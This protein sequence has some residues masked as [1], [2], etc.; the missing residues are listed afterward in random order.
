MK[1]I[2]STSAAGFYILLFAVSIGV[3]TFIENDFG[4][5]SA[6]KLV[7]KAWWFELLLTLFSITLVVNVVKFKMLQLK[8][9]PLFI[10][11]LSMVLILVGAGI[12]RYFSFE[13]TMHIREGDSSNTVLSR[14]NYLNFQAVS[15]GD[16]YEFSEP[17]LFSSIGNNSFNEKFNI[18]GKLVNV[19]VLDIMPNP[20]NLLVESENG[21]PI[22]KIV[23]GGSNG[24][25][26]FYI[27]D[28]ERRTISGLNFDFSK[29]LSDSSVVDFSESP[30]DISIFYEEGELFIKSKTELSEM[31]MIT[32]AQSILEKGIVHPLKLRSFYNTGEKGFV[33][34]AFVS[35]GEL[36][37][38]STDVKMDNS[39][40]VGVHLKVN[41]D[42]KE[43]D[44]Y[45]FGRTGGEGR[46]EVF[47][48]DNFE[49]SIS[50]G[51]KRINLPFGLYLNDF[52][53]DRY[54]GTNSPASYASEVTL[55]DDRTDIREDHRIYMNHILDHDGY[56]FFQSS[57]DQDELGTYL[58]VNHDYWGTL[59]TYISYALF[60]LGLV[61]VFFN[62][63]TRFSQLS[64]QLKTLQDKRFVLV[65]MLSVSSVMA[66]ASPIT[67]NLTYVSDSHA[68]LFNTTIV[69]D[70]KGRMKPMQ[71]LSNELLRK[72]H[73]KS[74]YQGH[75]AST[76]ILSMY[77]DPKVW[78]GAPMI[79][80]GKHE[81]IAE[82][83]GISP[84]EL[85]S[86][87]DFFFDD[88]SYKLGN[89]IKEANAKPP[90]ER[91]TYEKQLL[92]VDERV[93]IVGMV[94]AGS[95]FK[96]IPIENDVNNTWVAETSHL[97]ASEKLTSPVAEA[98][99]STYRRAVY[100]A[101]N[102]ASYELCDK[103]INELKNYQTTIGAAVIPSDLK[104]STE[105]A[106]NNS[107]VFNRLALFYF[108]LGMLFLGLLFY[109]V[110]F[111]NG[112]AAKFRSALVFLVFVGFI[113]HTTG[114]GA[115][116][117]I[118]GR[119]PWS[120]GYESMIYIAWT[121][122][123]AGL[124]FTRKSLGAMAA[125]MVL[126]GAVLLIAML[127]YLDP[128]ITPLVP[129]LKSYWLTIH[130]SLIAG[131]YGFLMLG[132]IIGLINLLMYMILSEKNKPNIIKIIKEMTYISEMTL[133]GGI[134]LLSV[135]TYL[136]GIWANESWGRYWGW[137]AKETWALV[138][139]LVYA[140]IL[141]MRL[142]PG[143]KSLFA[144]NFATL[145]G[146]S[147]VIMTYFGVNYYLSGMHSYAAGDPVPIP[148]WV[149]Y[150]V[151]AITIISLF[152]YLKKVKHKIS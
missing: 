15:Q 82:I 16:F 28:G 134:V 11:H 133:T 51:A 86:Y 12:T 30:A 87:K 75:S 91:G 37:L 29:S 104:I 52:I 23:F 41:I 145:F 115:R 6:M 10:F 124:I 138:S 110:F 99:F 106:L 96:V 38:T 137:D 46:A 121:S 129:V 83:L 66:F 140:F 60:T 22:L 123:L 132:A 130:V 33:F 81:G 13:G 59:I 146:L 54:P 68:T 128:E 3:A 125:T 117:Y 131:S 94:F 32:Q 9:W 43:F 72:V 42:D 21:Q 40:I 102:G 114:L 63:N 148:S 113:F 101:M 139:I 107:N 24:R 47:N 14:D 103:I 88:G 119:A 116:W 69:Q 108:L 34:G 20:D 61:L 17:V 143:L 27:G 70:F 62:K 48:V 49:F 2:F 71:T 55:I 78:Y 150:A 100:D 95:F 89:A 109:S 111:P 152:A 142:I 112:R 151:I 80:F 5:S 26:E 122:T 84:N 4:T 45:V 18:D 76:T 8:K 25:E 56:R 105:I 79:R 7:Y 90:I 85:A 144:Y 35:S 147:S 126:A 64:R 65:A 97:P 1:R 135:G 44:R 77:G 136:G 149:Y 141:H 53:M 67:P 74:K 19:E 50:Y 120:N 98:F 73:G 93:N 118:T 39:S 57:F 31:V 92:K 58:S 36:Q 127:S